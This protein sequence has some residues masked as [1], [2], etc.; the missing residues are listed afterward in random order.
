MAQEVTFE[1][2]AELTGTPLSIV[3]DYHNNRSP[4]KWHPAD[5]RAHSRCVVM[6]TMAAPKEN[7]SGRRTICSL[8]VPIPAFS[9]R[10]LEPLTGIEPVA[11][12]CHSSEYRD[13]CL[14][15]T[16]Y[17]VIGRDSLHQGAPNC[18]TRAPSDAGLFPHLFPHSALIASAKRGQGAA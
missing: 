1:R 10:I 18:S 15:S 13:T 2:Y 5:I 9:V 17:K 14:I 8:A 3:W 6:I 4:V 11:P 16:I 7:G 12:S